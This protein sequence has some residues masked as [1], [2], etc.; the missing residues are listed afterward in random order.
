M[1]V[2]TAQNCLQECE[3]KFDVLEE[4]TIVTALGPIILIKIKEAGNCL[5]GGP[6]TIKS[7]QSII[8]KLKMMGC[9]KILLDGAF[10]RTTLAQI[11][12]AT[13]FCV[14]AS[15]SS[16]LEKI[17]SHTIATV[18]LFQLPK[19]EGKINLS[20][21]EEVVLIDDE[22]KLS[23]LKTTTSL[24]FGKDII[25]QIT[26]NV[27]FVF[28]PK[29][30]SASFLQAFIENRHRLHCDLI[31][32]SPMHLMVDE[33]LLNHL[34]KL[35]HKIYVLQPINLIALTFNPF[36]TKGSMVSLSSFRKQLGNQLPLPIYDVLEESKND[37]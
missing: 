26:A 20:E 13:I 3:A 21:Q 9:H 11:S 34:F 17:A 30:V 10:S 4:T 18:K 2:A 14:G 5:V 25:S 35:K 19:Y 1:V 28:V 23:Y 27:R 16:Q 31:V 8:E 7:M 24:D 12:D 22:N 36:S 6:S 37:E 33:A 15:F 29:A 32:T